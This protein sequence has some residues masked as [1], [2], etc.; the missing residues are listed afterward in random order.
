ME[1]FKFN[2]KDSINYID[3]DYADYYI[4]REFKILDS[5]YDSHGYL[6]L[7][8]VLEEFGM[9]ELA[10]TVPMW[11][12]WDKTRGHEFKHYFEE[13]IETFDLMIMLN[14]YDISKEA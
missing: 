11:L 9:V 1:V 5:K 10:K 4:A 12:G 6:Y 3:A 8:Q 2:F 7:R 13:I 14:P